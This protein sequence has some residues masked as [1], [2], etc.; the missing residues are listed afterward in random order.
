MIN[1]QF[2]YQKIQTL[3][4]AVGLKD[5]PE[6]IQT[7][8]ADH[9]R[10]RPYQIEAIRYFV[11]YNETNL[12]MNKQ[13]DTLFHMATGSG[14][15]V[16]MAALILYLYTQGYRNFVFVVNQNN[17]IQK[18]KENFLNTDSNKYL[19]ADE[20]SYLGEKI[21]IREVNK[22]TG[23]NPQESFMNI[24]F[25]ST[26]TLHDRI[27]FPTEN[28]ISLDDFED[29]P[30][31]ILADESHH[32]NVATKKTSK[33]EEEVNSNW[34]QSIR[35][36]A[37]HSNIHNVM[38]EFTATIDLQ[39]ENILNKYVD[40]IVY[41]YSLK[42]FRES[43]FT[44][45]FKNFATDTDIWT[46]TLIA[47]VM[48][49]YRRYL[50]ADAGQNVKPVLMIQSRTKAESENFYEEFHDKMERLTGSELQNLHQIQNVPE[51]QQ[52]LKYFKA[53]D[54][55]L[56]L[57]AD[58]LRQS[59]TK[60]YS[61]N[62]NSSK[63][64]TAENH[65]LLNSLEDS[66]NPLRLIFTVKMLI[67]GWD[68]LNLFDIVRAFDERQ[69]KKYTLSEA[70]LIG[71]G[72]RYYP[73]QVTEDQERFRRK[74]DSDLDNPF[75]YLET[76]YFHSKNDSR[77][78]SEL[79][80]ALVMTGMVDEQKLKITYEL[81]D[82]FKETDLYKTGLVFSNSRVKKDRQV[83]QDLPASERQKIRYAS[84]QSQSGLVTDL[85]TGGIKEIPQAVIYKNKFTS[86]FKE[87]S[88]H[89]LLG[90][91]ES[92]PA[93]RFSSLK[94]KFPA[95][96]SLREFLTSSSY[97]GE[98]IL[99]MSYYSEEYTTKDI[100]LSLVEVFAE[101]A[102]FVTQVKPEYEGTKLFK[103]K[104]MNR[105]IRNKSIQL[106]VNIQDNLFDDD[107][108][109]LGISQKDVADERLRMDLSQE[110]WYVYQ[111]NYGTSEEKKFLVYK[112]QLK[113]P[114]LS[115][116]RFPTFSWGKLVFNS[117]RRPCYINE[118]RMM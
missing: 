49:E 69:A 96:R 59:M 102:R 41:D 73:F 9:I 24:H 7:G 76:M 19:F 51:L 18:T 83:V 95:L 29:V 22:F 116:L 33:G 4:E 50:F 62:I 63:E 40:K 109:G 101:I 12:S 46:R 6:I 15:T 88:Y 112:S 81:K 115:H 78:I 38:L 52:A 60:E 75:R 58:S 17:I 68:V 20:L 57:L 104:T 72:A 98:N 65:V 43:G 105:V 103:A 92:Y 31:V 8:L 47:C 48:S 110:D 85:L 42:H 82:S 64:N 13:I 107:R 1:Q 113:N 27:I 34:E 97:L 94:Q 55:T 67:E 118:I 79:R 84:R 28:S 74:Y 45:D 99:E 77:Y 5:L 66:S 10:L 87:I 108:D 89:T 35:G 3:K 61:L 36:R 70:Q 93:L 37:F 71:R 39:D 114:D 11:T 44:K 100:Y 117:I 80:E 106:S 23:L 86:P 21:E 53:K 54:N 16:I 56:N 26:N 90:A 30:V 111:D 91:S 14:K 32:L 25:S 2:L